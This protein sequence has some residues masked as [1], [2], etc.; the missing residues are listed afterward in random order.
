MDLKVRDVAALLHVSETAVRQW[1]SA[2]SIPFY[3]IGGQYRFNRQEIES[4]MLRQRWGQ[5][6]SDS[7]FTP[8]NSST[9]NNQQFSLYRALHRGEVF[10][11]AEGTT[12]EEVIRHATLHIAKRLELDGEALAHL[13]MEREQLQP[14]ALGSGIAVPHT[15]DF[16]LPTVH[17]V[18]AV[19]F[20]KEPIAY[21]ALDGQPVHTLIFLLACSD[22]RHLHLLAKI[23][24]CANQP[25]FQDFFSKQPTKKQLLQQVHAWESH[26]SL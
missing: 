6:E 14:T 24:H 23:A 11:Q 16:L 7:S 21:G 17:D 15:R 18:I 12:K 1:V 4:W 5:T 13:L 22:K 3:K 2:R 20:P 19:V 8:Q 10:N 25:Y 9:T 26:L